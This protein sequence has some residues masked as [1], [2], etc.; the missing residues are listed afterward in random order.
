[1]DIEHNGRAWSRDAAWDILAVVLVVDWVSSD[2]KNRT[3]IA[4]IRRPR[5]KSQKEMGI[6]VLQRCSKQ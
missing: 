1:M 4:K 5:Q 3:Y 2:W 6:F